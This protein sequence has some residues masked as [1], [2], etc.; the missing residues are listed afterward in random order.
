M[1]TEEEID[2]EAVQQSVAAEVM[3][4]MNRTHPNQRHHNDRG[5]GMDE[6]SDTEME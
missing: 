3:G 4:I 6:S 5:D 1:D 2:T